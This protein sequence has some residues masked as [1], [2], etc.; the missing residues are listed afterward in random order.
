MHG[1]LIGTDDLYG[2]VASTEPLPAVTLSTGATYR[3]LCDFLEVNPS[4]Q[5]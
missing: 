4:T 3:P 5:D 1:Y 2:V